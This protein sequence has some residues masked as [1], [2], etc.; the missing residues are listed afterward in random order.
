MEERLHSNSPMVKQYV[1]EEVEI[2]AHKNVLQ[3]SV[4]KN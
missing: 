2:V 1:D 4:E 3:S